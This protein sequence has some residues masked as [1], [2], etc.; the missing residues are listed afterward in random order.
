MWTGVP[1]GFGAGPPRWCYGDVPYGPAASEE[2]LK[3]RAVGRTVTIWPTSTA[4][5]APSDQEVIVQR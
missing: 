1:G 5:G 3:D 4:A 2:D